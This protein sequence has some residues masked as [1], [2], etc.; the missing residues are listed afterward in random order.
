MATLQRSAD[1]VLGLSSNVPYYTC[2]MHYVCEHIQRQSF[3][4][5][6]IIPTTLTYY[7]NNYHIYNNQFEGVEAQL[8]RKP[9]DPPTFEYNY[10]NPLESKIINYKY[11]PSIK[12][13]SAAV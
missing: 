6:K 8:S 13:P 12:F 5:Q 7:L 1:L 9:Y 3:G 4:T 11:H 2:L 10:D